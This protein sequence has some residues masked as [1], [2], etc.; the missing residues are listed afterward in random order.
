MNTVL[1]VGMALLA[2]LVGAVTVY[3][4]MTGM[5]SEAWRLF[6]SAF[7]WLFI[8]GSLVV[9][10]ATVCIIKMA[11]VLSDLVNSSVDW[12]LEVV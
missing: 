2:W 8:V 6:W 7:S 10:T 5:D 12:L 11:D 4:V 9:I 3:K 1:I